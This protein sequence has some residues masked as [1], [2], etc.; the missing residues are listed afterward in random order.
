M[1]K[2]RKAKPIAIDD[3]RV[4]A[5]LNRPT[6]KLRC[7]CVVRFEVDGEWTLQEPCPNDDDNIQKIEEAD[8]DG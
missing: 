6:L 2:K 3:R 7:G 5:Y 1:S 4:Q 8:R